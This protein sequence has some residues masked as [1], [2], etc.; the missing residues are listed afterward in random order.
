M[1]LRSI[2]NSLLLMSLTW[3][4][5][6]R[7]Q[8]PFERKLFFPET[9]KYAGQKLDL[10]ATRNLIELTP[11][12]IKDYG[13]ISDPASLYVANFRH[14]DKYWVARIP[15]GGVD[16]ALL[17]FQTLSGL[18]K[19]GIPKS[20][21]EW[22]NFGHI[23][24]RFILKKGFKIELVTQDRAKPRETAEVR[25]FAYALNAVRAESQVNSDYDPLGD[26]IKDGYGLSHTLISTEDSYHYFDKYKVVVNQYPLQITSGE[27]SRILQKYVDKSI[28]TLEN[29]ET[30]HTLL[31]SC[32]TA[33]LEQFYS[34][35]KNKAV[36]WYGRFW[37]NWR[38]LPQLA[39]T[40]YE[41]D[42]RA[43]IALLIKQK[44]IDPKKTAPTL[45]NEFKKANFC[46]GTF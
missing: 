8:D 2:F 26:G 34:V 30:Y 3:S 17:Q 19:L 31:R 4:L 41:F 25:D 9:A 24:M 21:I 15:K 42:P 27:A 13:F 40:T 36:I 46:A 45:G 37:R 23:Q 18:A 35:V 29:Q 10:S 12:Q 11:E 6:S 38:I 7:A 5:Q 43:V 22:I 1:K 33:T 16:Q 28:H 32:V 20:V 14:H 39:G 44:Y